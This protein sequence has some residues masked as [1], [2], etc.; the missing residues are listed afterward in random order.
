MSQDIIR[1]LKDEL[2]K[3]KSLKD[4]WRE[5]LD[6]YLISAGLIFNDKNQI[7]LVKHIPEYGIAIFILTGLKIGTAILK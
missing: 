4:L 3:I 7:L 1:Q 6:K 5:Y 2:E